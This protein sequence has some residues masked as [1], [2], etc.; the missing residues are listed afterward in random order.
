MGG[1]SASF[2]MIGDVVIAEPKALIGFAGPRVIEQT[3]RETLPE[4]FQRAEFLLEHGAIDLIVDRREMRDKLASVLT[5]FAEAARGSAEQR[6]SLSRSCT[7]APWR[8]AASPATRRATGS[9]ISSR[10][11]SAARSRW[12]STAFGRVRAR[13]A[14][15]PA[16][17]II[18]VGGTN[19]KGSSLRDARGD[20][21]CMPATASGC[22]T[23]PHLLRYNER[24]RIGGAKSAMTQLVAALRSASKRRAAT[25]R[26][27]ISSSARSRRA[28]VR[29]TPRVDVAVLEVG[30]GGRL[31]AVNVFDADCA[32]VTSVGLDHMDYLGDTREAI[33]L[34]KGGHLPRRPAGDLRRCRSAGVAARP[35]GGDRRGSHADRPRFR[36]RG[37]PQQWRY[38][39]PR[40]RAHG[41][42]YP[43]L[44]GA[45]QSAM[46]PPDCRARCLRE[47]PAGQRKDIRRACSR[48]RLPGRFQVLPGRPLVVLDVAHNPHA[49]LQ[50]SP[51]ISRACRRGGRTFAVFA[52]LKDKDIAG[53]VAAVKSLF[54]TGFLRASAALGARARHILSQRSRAR[55]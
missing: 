1:V 45:F 37:E 22:Y 23:S 24:V 34:E 16:F 55:A 17:P 26:S 6:L 3:V 19:G 27:R 48:R 46:R 20:P 29:A 31:D 44:R 43:A 54:R 25:R 30:L 32:I 50:R 7:H 13:S 12:G 36:L 42:P 40:R 38:W 9:S 8:P 2:A 4:G 35:R 33:G 18:T 49:A 47:R 15:S 41:L 52:M 11:A 51:P 5:L 28:A 10:L 21:A 39:G 14:I 53:V